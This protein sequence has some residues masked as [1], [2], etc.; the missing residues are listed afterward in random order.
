M[1][2]TKVERSPTQARQAVR[3]RRVFLVLSIS[4][5]LALIAMFAVLLYFYATHTQV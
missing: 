5:T 3:G 4:L 2:G 1:A